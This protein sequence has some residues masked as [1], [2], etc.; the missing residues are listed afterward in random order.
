MR[1]KAATCVFIFLW[2]TGF[3][4]SALAAS[5]PEAAVR[6]LA[7]AIREKDIKAFNAVVDVGSILDASFAR[8]YDGGDTVGFVPFRKQEIANFLEGIASGTHAR[9]CAE[10]TK[11]GCPWY[12]DGLDKAKIDRTDAVSAIVSVDSQKDIRSWLVLHRTPEGWKVIAAP[13]RFQH[14]ELYATKDFQKRMA[15]YR[16]ALRRKFAREA[17][18]EERYK[19]GAAEAAKQAVKILETVTVGNLSFSLGGSSG[20]YLTIRMTVTNGYNEPLRLCAIAMDIFDKAGNRV[21][22]KR[23]QDTT[24]YIEP[25]KNI[26]FAVSTTMSTESEMD[27]A[28]KLISGVYS[29]KARS[30]YLMVGKRNLHIDAT[31]GGLIPPRR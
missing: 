31:G 28:R 6:A 20:N 30:T 8:G 25:G 1:R 26:P 17:E 3:A 18:E 27:M 16:D 2:I 19:K 10:A 7:S 11:P 5:S 29:A 21:E 14:A 12:P 4:G 23:Y 15:Q 22:A 9:M 24:G 13:A